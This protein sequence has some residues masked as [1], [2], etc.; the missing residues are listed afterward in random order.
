MNIYLFLKRL[1]IYLTPK[2]MLDDKKI[3]FFI[4]N[5]FFRNSI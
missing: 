4:N 3:T 2:N 1:K 5:L